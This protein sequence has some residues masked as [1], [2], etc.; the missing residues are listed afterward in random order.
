MTTA[1]SDPLASS[2]TLVRR[3]LDELISTGNLALTPQFLSP[4]H[5][6]HFAGLPTMDLQGWTQASQGYFGGF[7]DLH[8]DVQDVVAEGD[9]VVVRWTWTGTHRGPFMGVP[10]TGRQVQGTG[11]GIYRIADGLIAEQWVTE[12][13]TLLMQQLQGQM[14]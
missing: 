9:R 12:D 14:P 3:F 1:A 8:V 4:D 13:M 10:A 2:K 6:A 11:V 7:P 5:V